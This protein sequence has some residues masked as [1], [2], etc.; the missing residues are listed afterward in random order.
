M[1]QAEA[2]MSDTAMEMQK[3]AE[4]AAEKVTKAAA[5]PEPAPEPKD[6]AMAE[7][8]GTVHEVKMLN[9]D[10]DDRSQK[11]VY[12]PRVLRISPGDTVRFLPSDPGHN[13]ASSRGMLPDGAEDWKSR[14]GQEFEV[15]L[16]IPGIYGYN[17]TPHKASGMV[18]L[19]VVEGEGMLDNLEEAKSARQVG[20]ARQV[21]AD[22]WD[23][24]DASG[25]LTP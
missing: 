17:C 18:G 4:D 24:A 23:E 2:A 12:K 16:S 13:S 9:T 11:M 22:I 8:S 15:T 3:E 19:I 14:I 5:K 25:V 20:K 1:K 10:P 21:W 6:E 7:T